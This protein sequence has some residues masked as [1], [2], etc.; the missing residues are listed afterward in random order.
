MHEA[1]ESLQS[2]ENRWNRLGAEMDALSLMWRDKAANTFAETYWVGF[3]T[4][5]NASLSHLRESVQ[6]LER[7]A[8]DAEAGMH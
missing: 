8:G 1:I 6:E 7:L 2:L 3:S 5:M 4:L